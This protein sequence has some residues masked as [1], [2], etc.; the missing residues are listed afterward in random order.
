MGAIL[1]L[2]TVF[3]LIYSALSGL[4]GVVYTDL[5]QFVMAMIGSIALAVI[6]YYDAA[7]SAEG[8]VI[9]L[10]QSA[11]GY[12]DGMLNLFPTLNTWTIGTMLFCVNIGFIWIMSF[13]TGGFYV[14]RLLSTKNEKEATKAFMWY[15][16]AN[17]VLRSW[18]WIVVGMLSLY[19]FPNIEIKENAYVLSI[20]KFLPIGLKGLMMASFLAAFMSTMSTQLNW[21]TSY[22][23]HDLYEAF[24]AP[25]ASTKHIVVVSRVCMVV[26]TV[27]AAIVATQ[28]S[29]NLS[30]YTFLMQFWAGMGLILIARWYWW[31]ITA[32]AEF[33]CMLTIVVF[34]LALNLKD[35]NGVYYAKGFYDFFQN[36]LN[37]HITTEEDRGW[38]VWAVRMF[39][40]TFLPPVIWVP[41]AFFR[42][43]EPSASAIDFY[44]KIRINSY[45][46]KTVEKITGL[47]AP[48]G[49]FYG[50]M[51][52]WLV[53]SVTLYGILL[54][55]GALIFQMWVQAVVLLA[56]GAVGAKMTWGIMSSNILTDVADIEEA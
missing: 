52:G 17:F 50:N 46:W 51:K 30:A 39:V 55:T 29:T 4:Y 20:D 42:T 22:I 36:L 37:L 27:L 18:P 56:I 8:G 54:G 28:L 31:R 2:L 13:P 33:I 16:F 49:E 19:Y 6:M 40:F 11:P 7:N 15:N 21:G 14:Q 32:G 38:L 47:A 10:I 48:K 23:I 1:F 3:V 5:F 41:Y 45:G 44:K 24:I 34:I 53:T 25:N 9:E 35:S 12:R 43:K 26:F